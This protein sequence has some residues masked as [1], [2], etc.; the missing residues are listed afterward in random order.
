VA[1]M[2]W[3]DW[4]VPA[5]GRLHSR[6]LD[7]CQFIEMGTSGPFFTGTDK[8]Q[9]APDVQAIGTFLGLLQTPWPD[10]CLIREGA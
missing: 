7:C 9:A 10:R 3:P 2:T 5:L 4:Q 6:Q 1:C 8:S